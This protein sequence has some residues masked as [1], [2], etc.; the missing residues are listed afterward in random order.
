MCEKCGCDSKKILI[1]F[2]YMWFVY[3]PVTKKLLLTDILHNYNE[4]FVNY[5][6]IH[7]SW[8]DRP[9]LSRVQRVLVTVAFCDYD[10]RI[11]FVSTNSISKISRKL[12]SYKGLMIETKWWFSLLLRWVLGVPALL[13]NN[14]NTK[15]QSLKNAFLSFFQVQEVA[16]KWLFKKLNGA[17][18]R[19]R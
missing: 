2:W 4:I 16:T 12:I 18:F 8:T 7:N 5:K 3:Y 10:T 14:N 11:R 19:N 1:F 6:V 9:F 15:T 13:V 17:H